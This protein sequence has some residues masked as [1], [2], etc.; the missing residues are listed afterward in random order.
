MTGS[1]GASPAFFVRC[2]K[3]WAMRTLVAKA[4][5]DQ[6][7]GHRLMIGRQ[8]ATAATALQVEK[9]AHPDQID[10]VWRHE[11]AAMIGMVKLMTRFGNPAFR[12]S[13]NEFLVN[14]L[15]GQEYGRTMMKTSPSGMTY[16]PASRMRHFGPGLRRA[17]SRT[18][19]LLRPS[20]SGPAPEAS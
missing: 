15:S 5:A 16:V 11:H 14:P 10:N 17:S 8:A 19:A 3:A 18:E 1:S 12:E 2:P 6:K 13:R 7:R 20:E 9:P 4:Q